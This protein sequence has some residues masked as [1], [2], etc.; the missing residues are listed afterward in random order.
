MMKR[1]VTGAVALAGAGAVALGGALPSHA[2]TQTVAASNSSAVT[3]KVRYFNHSS[4][5]YHA[6]AV[7]PATWK[8]V[9]LGPWQARFDDTAHNRMIRFNTSYD[10]NHGT[11]TA[12][13]QK[14]KSLKG[15]RGLHI[16]GTSTVTMKSASGLGPLRVSTVVYTYR[17][18]NTTRWVATRYVGTSGR[19]ADD[20]EISTAGSP[21]DSKL[22][23]TTLNKATVSLT[24]AG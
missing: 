24:L 6:S 4:E 22:L 17:S 12:L 14:I 16:V 9:A 8:S 3:Y 7:L 1:I 10:G 20:V 2:S 5:G 11:I 15:T 23:G 21:R 18:G 13:N 19:N